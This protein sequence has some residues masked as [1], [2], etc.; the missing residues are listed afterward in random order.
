MMISIKKIIK[1]ILLILIAS[2][3]AV[4]CDS[5]NQNNSLQVEIAET[6]RT[7]DDNIVVHKDEV[8]NDEE[9]I[10]EVRNP[11]MNGQN[12]LELQN[13]LLSLGFNGIGAADGYFGPMSEGVIKKIQTFSG[14]ESNG[15]VNGILLNFIFDN[16]NTAL[17]RNI[18]IV[19]AYD[20][21]NLEK[22]DALIEFGPGPFRP[23]G[24]V[25]YSAADRKAKIIEYNSG[26]ESMR[27][28]IICYFINDDDYFLIGNSEIY[29]HANGTSDFYSSINL[30]RDNNLYKIDNGVIT[31]GSISGGWDSSVILYRIDGIKNNFYY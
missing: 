2:T 8:V 7:V 20:Q 29:D 16:N 27:G 15:K 31:T 21:N 1:G 13:R 25:Y 5:K 9:V 28:S 17:L 22:T 3:M 11:R 4:S 19:S 10:F 12:V 23:E 26:D 18:N 30:F 14:F 24:F 6:Q